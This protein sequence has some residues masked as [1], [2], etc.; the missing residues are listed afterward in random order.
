M[1]KN[2]GQYGPLL[3]LAAG[4]CIAFGACGTAMAQDFPPP[5]SPDSLF[6]LESAL[7]GAGAA[8]L[9]TSQE[10]QL[11]TLISDFRSSQKPPAPSE[12]A[13]TARASYDNAIVACDASAAA[14]QIPVLVAE[15]TSNAISRMQA[16]ISFSINVIQILQA[17]ANQ[18]NLLQQY[19]GAGRLV[20]LIGSLA[21]GPGG[22]PRPPGPPPAQ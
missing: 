9:T 18:L 14:A 17:N 16:Q 2:C 21:G 13:Q 4:L 5:Q 8:A 22:G 7:S 6:P 15:Q 3:L 20:R 10:E 1:S 19:L 11:K 12:A